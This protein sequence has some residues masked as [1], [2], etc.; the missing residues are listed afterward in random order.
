MVLSFGRNLLKKSKKINK[1]QLSLR[2]VFGLCV[3]SEFRTFLN[4]DNKWV[5]T[6]EKQISDDGAV[7]I[8]DNTNKIIYYEKIEQV[9][10]PGCYL[11]R[12]V[13]Q[14]MND[15][16]LNY[17]NKSK[18]NGSEYEADQSLFV[19]SDIKSENFN[20]IFEWKD[21]VKKFF[22]NYHFLHLYFLTLTKHSR[23][24]N[25][26][27]FLSFTNQKHRQHLNGE[28]KFEVRAEGF[29]NFKCLQKI[30]LMKKI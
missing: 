13:Y 8:M 17:I 19:L 2:E 29:F 1:Y 9:Y 22:K 25:E 18:N 7:A 26:Y 20:D 15:Y 11:K 10:L 27:Y 21:F 30:N 16:I 12:D 24:S 23:K 6:T 5:F 3:L 28:F 4:A 14:S